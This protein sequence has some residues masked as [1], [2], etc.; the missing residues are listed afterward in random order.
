MRALH[1][2]WLAAALVLASCG[3]TQP[4][5]PPTPEASGLDDV[6]YVAVS[7]RLQPHLDPIWDAHRGRY[8][9]PGL[10]GTV[11]Q[12]NANLLLVHATA[13]RL[14]LTG[15][16]RDDRRARG[17]VAYLIGPQAWTEHPMPDAP[18]W[19]RGPGWRA[20][21]TNPNSHLVFSAEVAEA[22]AAAYRARDAL[23]LDPVTIATI[24]D[25]IAR[26][27]VGPDFAWPALRL[28]QL[29]WHAALFAADATVNGAQRTFAEG[30][31][32]HLERFTGGTLAPADTPN[33]GPGLRFRY[34]P[35]RAATHPANFDSA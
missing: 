33:L 10:S 30:L 12:I 24:R 31:G 4:V 6:G 22:L 16:P 2:P 18:P 3:S 8:E 35:A 11:A 23:A 17:I 21:P 15:P 7:A 27:A 19:L 26:T 28:N 5:A 13:A 9:P 25:Q 20:A 32:Q 34:L 14:G 29:N 1:Q